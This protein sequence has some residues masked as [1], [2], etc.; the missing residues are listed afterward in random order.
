MGFLSNIFGKGNS[1]KETDSRNVEYADKKPQ[2]F[3]YFTAKGLTLFKEED[4]EKEEGFDILPLDDVKVTKFTNIRYAKGREVL[5]SR[6][7]GISKTTYSKVISYADVLYIYYIPFKTEED[8][9]ENR[10][11]IEDYFN[12]IQDEENSYAY[13]QNKNVS[14][15]VHLNATG[16]KGNIF[17]EHIRDSIKLK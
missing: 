5:G 3:G 15:V 11:I 2:D 9:L 12:S 10:K 14:I 8:N 7:Q 1:N 4:W 17:A 16:Y 6:T 13:Y